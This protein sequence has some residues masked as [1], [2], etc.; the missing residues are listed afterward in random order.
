M[1]ASQS[2]AVQ[3]VKDARDSSSCHGP[4]LQLLVTANIF[5]GILTVYL[6]HLVDRVTSRPEATLLTLCKYHL[7]K[8][9][10]VAQTNLTGNFS[11]CVLESQFAELHVHARVEVG[12]EEV[13][14]ELVQSAHV[15][16][17]NTRFSRA[18]L[19]NAS[20]MHI[21]IRLFVVGVRDLCNAAIKSPIG[22]RSD[23]IVQGADFRPM[24]C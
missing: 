2:Q 20:S 18:A 21:D 6:Q 9:K 3:D 4:R 13:S 5:L 23:I 15:S 22:G 12:G 19:L 8:L 17:N 7:V 14:P 16:R 24:A 11:I 1:D 10:Q